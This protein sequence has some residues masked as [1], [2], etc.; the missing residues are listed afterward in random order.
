VHVVTAAILCSDNYHIIIFL[1]LLSSA[2]FNICTKI[3]N[4][5]SNNDHDDD[6]YNVYSA[7]FSRRVLYARTHNNIIYRYIIIL[8]ARILRV[9]PC[10]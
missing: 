7:F 2:L 3:N 5:D 10:T 6:D 1:I 8:Y 9:M 4:N